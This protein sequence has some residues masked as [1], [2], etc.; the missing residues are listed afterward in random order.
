MDLSKARPLLS[1]LVGLTLGTALAWGAAGTS[2]AGRA[3]AVT[4]ANASTGRIIVIDPGHGGVYNNASSAGVLEK[5]VNLALALALRDKLRGLGFTVYLT[6]STDTAVTL[7][8]IPTWNFIPGVGRWLFAR[9]YVTSYSSGVPKDDL[10]ARCDIASRLGA[11]AFISVHCNG[12]DTTAAHGVETWSTAED[13]D[14]GRLAAYLQ[15]RLAR[16]TGLLDRGA[17]QAGFYVLKWTNMPAALIE[18]GFISNPGDRAYLLSPTGRATWATSVAGGLEQWLTWDAPRRHFGRVGG[19]EPV[20]AAVALSKLLAPSGAAAV[21]IANADHWSDAVDV[22]TLARRMNAP[23]LY[24]RDAT[25]PAATSAELARLKAVRIVV[26]GR[27]GSF[28]ATALAGLARAASVPTSVVTWLGGADAMQTAAR[29]ARRLGL[30][31]SKRVFVA[32][33]GGPDAI[34]AAAEAA[35]QGA[36]VLLTSATGVSTAT[37]SAVA[38]LAVGETVVVGGT[39]A[40]PPV[41][42]ARFPRPTRV[43]GADRYAT[44]AA[45]FDAFHASGTLQPVFA[46]TDDPALAILAAVYAGRSARPLALTRQRTIPTPLRVVLENAGRRVAGVTMVSGAASIGPLVDTAVLKALRGSPTGTLFATVAAETSRP[47]AAVP[48]SSPTALQRTLGLIA[49]DP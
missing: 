18:A 48:T 47:S 15:G 22:P 41:T 4:P 23:V 10:Q 28:D 43:A 3:S 7:S 12:M 33:E 30:Q 17:K 8:D 16:D 37:A 35:C 1:V 20:S 44:N 38:S 40:V 24:T 9:D 27:S 19:D 5:N 13:A 2:G 31:P 39:A 34:T 42:L 11:D 46:T 36:P 6:R 25:L 32:R 49:T 26:V 14:G 29:L 45:V 21:V